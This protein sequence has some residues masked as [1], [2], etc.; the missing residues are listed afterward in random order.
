MYEI[1]FLFPL[2]S[3][4]YPHSFPF[5]TGILLVL[6]ATSITSLQASDML[7]SEGE[8]MSSE[9]SLSSSDS[10][11]SESSLSSSDCSGDQKCK[12]ETQPLGDKMKCPE[13]FTP[14]IFTESVGPS[15][16]KRCGRCVGGESCKKEGKECMFEAVKKELAG[17]KYVEAVC[18]CETPESSSSS[19]SS[20]SSDSSPSSTSSDSSDSSP[21]STSSDSSMSFN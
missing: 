20:D 2:F 19:I 17:V 16:E 14:Y 6:S 10:S 13:G 5:V 12:P 3:M 4:K 18:S 7:S 21:S 9:S 1:L 11:S 15:F 8:T